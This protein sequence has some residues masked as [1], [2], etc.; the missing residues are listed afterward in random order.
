RFE[1]ALAAYREAVRIRRARVNGS[2]SLAMSLGGLAETLV[3]MKRWSDARDA[4]EATLAVDRALGADGEINFHYDRAGLAKVLARLDRQDEART[5]FDD[6]LAHLDRAKV[7]GA[8][9]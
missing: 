1:E 5:V 8:N 7:G 4:Y 3:A 9:L 2:M 6:A